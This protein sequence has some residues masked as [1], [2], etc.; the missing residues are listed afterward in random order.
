MER[1]MLGKRINLARKDRKLT[2]EKLSEMC[3]INAT[4]LR[5]IESGIKMPSLPV[6]VSICAA[7]KTSPAFLLADSLPAECLGG[8]DELLLLMES[9]SPS[10]MK[11]ATAMIRAA[12]ESCENADV[13][14]V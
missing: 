13:F 1:E 7:L 14:L 12:L 2:S 11:L 4:Y 3:N 5:Q 9:A 10:Q 8:S 6:F